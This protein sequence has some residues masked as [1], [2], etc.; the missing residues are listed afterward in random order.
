MKLK[1]KLMKYEEI[2]EIMYKSCEDNNIPLTH[3]NSEIAMILAKS[4]AEERAGHVTNSATSEEKRKLQY[5][6]EQLPHLEES[7]ES[8]KLVK[9]KNQLAHLMN[10]IRDKTHFELAEPLDDE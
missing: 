8:Q 3:E 4:I 2:R 9:A 6:D 5:L 7:I 10:V 1:S